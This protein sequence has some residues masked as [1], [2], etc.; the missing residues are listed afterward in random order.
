MSLRKIFSLSLCISAIFCLSLCTREKDTGTVSF[1]GEWEASYGDTIRFFRENGKNIVSYNQSI[2]AFLTTNKY[3]Y[4]YRGGKLGIKNGFAGPDFTTYQTF[5]WI[6]EGKSFRI[7]GVDWFPFISST[8]T[9]YT[10]TKI[11]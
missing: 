3:E 2:S 5:T 7:Q 8:T 9:W 1:R 11:P 4:T 6:E 10:F